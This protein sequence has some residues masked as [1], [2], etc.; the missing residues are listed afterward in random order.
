M[1]RT[2]ST[3]C[4]IA[5]AVLL[6]TRGIAA[7]RK[8]FVDMDRD[9][10]IRSVPELST[11]EFDSSQD[12]LEALLRD[13]GAELAKMFG[14]FADASMVETIHEI[15]FDGVIPQTRRREEFLYFA[16]PATDGETPREFRGD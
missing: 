1:L 4:L 10:L 16:Q 2:G 9:E 13:T 3:F 8:P 6:A 11:L 5:A 15:R 12:R 14:D 7:D